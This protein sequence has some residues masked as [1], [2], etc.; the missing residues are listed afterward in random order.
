ME[1]L[2][3]SLMLLDGWYQLPQASRPRSRLVSAGL[4]EA[5]IS[6]KEQM[7]RKVRTLTEVNPM[8]GHRGVRLGITYPEIYRMQIRAILEAEAECAAK[9]L[10]VRSADDG[11]A[12]L[13][14]GRAALDQAVRRRDPCRR[15]TARPVRPSIAAS[16]P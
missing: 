7:L 3:G 2:A 11:A 10:E 4:V 6:K 15:G 1:V 12:G 5:A 13:Y 9:G 16:V 8:L 14:R